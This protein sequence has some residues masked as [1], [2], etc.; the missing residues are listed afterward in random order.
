MSKTVW[1][2]TFFTHDNIYFQKKEVL[3]V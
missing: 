3:V 2:A 1:P